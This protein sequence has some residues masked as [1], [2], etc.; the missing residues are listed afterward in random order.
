MLCYIAPGNEASPR[1]K[2]MALRKCPRCELN[3]ILDDGDLCSVCREEV[4]GASGRDDAVVMCSVCGEEPALPGEDVCKHCLADLRYIHLLST[5]EEEETG[6]VDAGGV[7]VPHL[8]EMEEIESVK[9][10]RN[11]SA[12]ADGEND[13]DEDEDDDLDA[14]L[15]G[16][17]EMEEPP[18]DDL[19]QLDLDN[20]F[21]DDDS[22]A[23]DDDD[24]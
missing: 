24:E 13:G 1:R 20:P 7:D 3:Y 5:D 2:Y 12:G 8:S 10:K 4:R 6:T 19:E 21:E 14:D 23:P 16:E 11:P 17:I 18:L 15:D 9:R 22:G